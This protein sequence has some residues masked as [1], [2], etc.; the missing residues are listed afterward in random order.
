MNTDLLPLTLAELDRL[1]FD[2]EV[3]AANKIKAARPFSEERNALL[4]E[5]YESVVAI[6]QEKARKAHTAVAS[7]G[8]KDRNCRLVKTLIR[9]H[10][11][12]TQK[13]SIVFYEAGVGTGLVVSSLLSEKNV[14]IQGCDVSLDQSLKNNPRLHLCEDTIF[15][16]LQKVEDASIDVFYW[17]DVLEHILDDEI[18]EYMTLIYQKIADNGVIITITP[19]RLYGPCD[20]TRLFYPPGTK[21]M[22]FH[23]HEY[24][25]AEV[26]ALMLAHLFTNYCSVFTNPITH[27]YVISCKCA[28]YMG[29]VIH[30]AAEAAARHFRPFLLRKLFLQLLGTH[31]SV[32]AKSAGVPPLFKH[33][34]L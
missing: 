7:Y 18:N 22:G 26:T 34:N 23:F 33:N 14:Y 10:R 20:V 9:K 27:R 13:D 30:I 2:T 32:F 28:L 11:K 4:K 12:Q 3:A 24:T 17:N 21:A 16:A 29:G 5:G 25:Y 6:A 15:D 8:A 19:N 31:V 1:A